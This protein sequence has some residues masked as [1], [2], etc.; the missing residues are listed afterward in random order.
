MPRA[1]LGEIQ[2]VV[3]DYVKLNKSAAA[4]S[5]E[6]GSVSKLLN[7]IGKTFMINGIFADKL[8]ELDGEELPFGKTIEEYY[9]DLYLPMDYDDYSSDPSNAAQD[10]LKPYYPQYEDVLFS[11]TLKRKK[12]PTTLKY[13]EYEAGVA[14]ADEFARITNIVLERLYET[15]AQFKYACKKQMLTNLAALCIN[16]QSTSGATAY[17]T[18]STV[19]SRGT[20]YSQSGAAY[21][22]V[23]S[24]AAAI[25]KTLATLAEE[26]EYVVKV[27]LVSEL[28]KPVDTTTG[29]AF[30]LD[31]RSVIEK[32]TDASKESLN[33]A[34][35]GAPEDG[36][37][38]I[39]KQGIMPNINV[40]VEAGAFHLDKV[41]VPAEIKV[42]NSM[43]K[44]Y[45]DGSTTQ[46]LANEPYAILIDRRALR[47]HPTYVRVREQDNGNADYVNFFHHSEHT[48]FISKN[49]FV[50][51]WVVPGA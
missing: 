37:L 26:G 31:V 45:N 21:I 25:N 1:S 9:Q 50:H 24:A 20:R 41:A 38:L 46:A 2:N 40:H 12:I 29:E 10:A 34:A 33:G 11:Y 8:P 13:D 23:K 15:Y 47:L 35:I 43:P 30:I 48:A 3:K 16:T 42:V 17:T 14:N 19:L 51:V 44:T 36:L 6:F 32:A 4:W 5:A 7:K 28:A 27:E 18:N 22:C 49:C 39:V